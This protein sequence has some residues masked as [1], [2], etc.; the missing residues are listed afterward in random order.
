MIVRPLGMLTDMSNSTRIAKNTLMLY[1]RQILIMLVSLYTV[2]VVLNTLGAEDYGIYNVVAG[3]V[4]MF[5]FLNV[6]LVTGTQRFLTFQLGRENFDELKKIFSVALNIHIILAIG[7]LI[8]AESIG[9]WFLKYKLNLPPTR[10]DAIFW[11]FQFSVFAIILTVIQAPYNASIIA[12]ER[13]NVFAYISIGD[14]AL[15]LFNAYILTVLNYDKLIVYAVLIFIANFIVMNLYRLYCINH[16]S[17]CRFKLIKDITLYKAIL[18]FSGWGIVGSG[19]VVCANQGV[20]ILL[21][22]FFGPMINA[23]RGI[24]VQINT[25]LASFV[26]NFQ[27]AVNPQIIKSYASEKTEELYTLLFQN[28]KFSFCILWVLLLPVLLKI[29]VLLHFWLTDI[30]EYTS[31]FCRLI[32]IQSLIFCMD[33]PFVTALNAIGKMKLPNLTAGIVLLLVLPISYIMLK[34]NMPAYIP[35]VVYICIN[36]ITTVIEIVFLYKW[37]KL[38]IKTL[39]K[40]VYVPISFIIVCSLPVSI[41]INHFS[42][43]TFFSS[44]LAIVLI[45]TVTLT[46]IY[47]IAFSKEMRNKIIYRILKKTVGKIP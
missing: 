19:A 14:A 26:N 1:F 41:L 15:K 31:L 20:N 24:A 10:K 13:M 5:G 11:V 22:I 25:A 44:L 16:Y 36:I 7:I 8:L 30:P 32:L 28:T 42:Y 4:T 17:E 47:F 43:D 2:R 21:N 38:P 34:E 45:G 27:T 40:Q 12:H 18:T 39:I 3:V 9:L 33:R 23:A 6:T 37:I 35:F 29:D 46:S